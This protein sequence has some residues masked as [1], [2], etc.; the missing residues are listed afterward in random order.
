MRRIGIIFL[1]LILTGAVVL[2]GG[3]LPYFLFYTFTLFVIIPLIHSLISFWGLNAEILIPQNI[4][5][6]ND[7]VNI[8]YKIKNISP[9]IIPYLAIESKMYQR[10]PSKAITSLPGRTISK[11]S[12]SVILRK[13]GYCNVGGIDLTIRDIYKIFKLKKKFPNKKSLLV[14]PKI[15][16]LSS[17]KIAHSNYLGEFIALDGQFDD[18]TMMNSLREYVHGDNL[19]SIHWKQTAK[20]TQPVIKVYDKRADAK[21]LI[22]VDNSI[23]SYKDDIDER[24]EDKTVDIALSIT[25]YY[26]NKNIDFKL[27]YQDKD[28]I[29]GINGAEADDIRIFLE[30]FARLEADGEMLFHDFLV[31]NVEMSDKNPIVIIIT[32]HLDK[33]IGAAALELLSRNAA[34][35]FIIVGDRKRNTG[36]LDED[37]Q[38]KLLKENISV[39]PLDY[40]ADI[41]QVLEYKYE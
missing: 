11:Y 30:V 24:L 26:F 31:N 1:F 7:T 8:N 13:R 38:K 28:K 25:D 3:R 36:F 27:F 34:P 4:L 12:E 19:K 17:L 9:F 22:F 35:F 14:Y 29:A 40:S 41:K 39:Y 16:P 37:I 10:N 32:P 2:V 23:H 21:V 20:K 6:K 15:I 33:T 5:Y 18:K